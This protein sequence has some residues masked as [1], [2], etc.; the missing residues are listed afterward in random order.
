M[1]IKENTSKPKL[2]IKRDQETPIPQEDEYDGEYDEEYDEEIVDIDDENMMETIN[3]DEPIPKRTPK[4][5]SPKK[6][7]KKISPKQSRKTSP[8]E[9]K[10]VS[11]KAQEKAPKSSP[12][13]QESFR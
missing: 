12:L 9:S 7:V 1:M 6:E 8:K 5:I 3:V 10:K 11:P 13:P 4:K 2:P